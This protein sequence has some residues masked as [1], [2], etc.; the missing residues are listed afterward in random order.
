VRCPFYVAPSASPC[1][2]RPGESFIPPCAPCTRLTYH[3]V[4][5]VGLEARC[6]RGG[7]GLEKLPPRVP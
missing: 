2:G 6:W 7:R 1:L 5:V 4:I 3:A